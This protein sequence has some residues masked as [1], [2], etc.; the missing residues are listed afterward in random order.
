MNCC[1]ILTKLLWYSYMYHV[2]VVQYIYIYKLYAAYNILIYEK[3][4]VIYWLICCNVPTCTMYMLYII[5][6]YRYIFIIYMQTIYCLWY[7]DIPNEMLWYTDLNFMMFLGILCICC[8]YTIL[9][10]I[11]HIQA[12]FNPFYMEC[13]Q[14]RKNKC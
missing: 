12:Q 9:S 7:F 8:V 2:Y 5:C 4:V 3:T 14:F 6:I 1:D 10:Y 13:H 11:I